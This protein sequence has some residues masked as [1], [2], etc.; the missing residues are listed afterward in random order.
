MSRWLGLVFVVFIYASS[1]GFGSYL[2]LEYLISPF[3]SVGILAG[4]LLSVFGFS[5]LFKSKDD[6][7]RRLFFEVAKTSTVLSGIIGSLIYFVLTLGNPSDSSS[8]RFIMASVF[9]NLFYT[10]IL[11]FLFSLLESRHEIRENRKFETYLS[12]L[13]LE[14]FG[15]VALLFIFLTYIFFNDYTN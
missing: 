11:Y 9:F 3:V 10:G 12:F 13:L 6:K 15:V 7:R 2:P 14:Y 8:Y 4:A 1:G 5:G